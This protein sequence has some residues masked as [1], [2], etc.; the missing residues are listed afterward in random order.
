MA[1]NNN[2]IAALKKLS[3]LISNDS[4]A[5]ESFL[6]KLGY[7]LSP[8]DY[9]KIAS[10]NDYIYINIDEMQSIIDPEKVKDENID[11][12]IISIPKVGK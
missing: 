5:R 9:L 3:N 10:D 4:N 11:I 1:M 6:S 2:K 8:C 12:G 7:Y